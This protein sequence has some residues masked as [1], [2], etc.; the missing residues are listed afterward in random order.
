MKANF[1]VLWDNGETEFVDT[2]DI[3]RLG[4]LTC[5]N[6]PSPIVKGLSYSVYQN[7]IVR[8]MVKY[9]DNRKV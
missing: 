8:D 3:A 2:L 5:E 4:K 1:L 7:G 9:P 6:S